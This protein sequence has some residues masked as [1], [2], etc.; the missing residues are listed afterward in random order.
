MPDY[1]LNW[2][3]YKGEKGDY[4]AALPPKVGSA[5]TGGL[6]AS[7]LPLMFDVHTARM[8]DS[9]AKKPGRQASSKLMLLA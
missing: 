7:R 3:T 9:R 5:K 6:S 2:T 4:D 1:R 8:P